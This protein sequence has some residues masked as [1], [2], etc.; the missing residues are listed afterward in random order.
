MLKEHSLLKQKY[1]KLSE[2]ASK[3]AH[4]YQTGLQRIVNAHLSERLSLSEQV[5]LYKAIVGELKSENQDIKAIVKE[6]EN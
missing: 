6:Q 2:S 5:Q 1:S 3:E 4:E